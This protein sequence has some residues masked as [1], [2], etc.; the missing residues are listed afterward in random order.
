M[1]FDRYKGSWEVKYNE[2]NIPAKKLWNKMCA[3]YNPRKIHINESETVLSF[4]VK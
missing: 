2:A 4:S 3:K 1:I